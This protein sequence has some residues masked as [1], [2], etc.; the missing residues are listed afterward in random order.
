M[1]GDNNAD[2]SANSSPINPTNNELSTGQHTSVPVAE[3]IFTLAFLCS[4]ITKSFDGNRLELHEFISNCESAFRFATGNQSEALMAFV[5]SKITGSARAQVRD[6][7]I[8][9]WEELKTLLLQLY[10]DKKHY[11]QLMEELNTIKQHANETVLS[12]YNRVDKLCT[13]LLNSISCNQGELLGRTETIKELSLQRFIFHSLPDISR[14]LRSQGPKDLATAFNAAIE[15]E[16]ALQISKQNRPILQ[17][18][19]YCSICKTKTHN[20]QNCYKKGNIQVNQPS[21]THNFSKQGSSANNYNGNYSK[22]DTNGNSFSSKNRSGSSK[23]CNYCKKNGH[24]INE[25]YKRNKKNFNT[26]N[27]NGAQVSA[28]STENPD[29]NGQNSQNTAVSWEWN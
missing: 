10:S 11:S 17:K 19:K 14:F 27:N 20:T 29:L 16:R 22:T 25:C 26:N 15:E 12:F 4:L 21:N 7:A 13:R 8:Q 28:I 24:L 2:S 18:T 1:P 9:T 3:S 23:F 5:I 6:K